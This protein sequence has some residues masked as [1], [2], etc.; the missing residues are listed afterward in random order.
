MCALLEHYLKK[1]RL[2]SLH[3][4]VQLNKQLQRAMLE[5]YCFFLFPSACSYSSFHSFSRSFRYYSLDNAFI[6][7][8]VGKKLSAKIR[9]DIDEISQQTGIKLASCMRQFDNLRL[10]SVLA[11]LIFSLSVRFSMIL[12]SA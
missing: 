4:I 5:M 2:F 3:S 7:E 9:K 1:P 10:V 12:P 8:I 6:R 11:S